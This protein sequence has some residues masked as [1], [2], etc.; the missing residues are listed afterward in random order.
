M[1]NDEL[2]A[3]LNE[4]INELNARATGINDG[5][6]LQAELRD[7][8]GPLV[9]GLTGWTWGGCGYIDVLWVPEDRRGKGSAGGSSTPQRP[10]H[11]GAAAPRL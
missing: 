7:D 2:A 3:E 6:L 8:E 11:M 4:R 1:A 5:R 10:R 9:A